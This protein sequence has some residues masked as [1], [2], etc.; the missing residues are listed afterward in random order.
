MSATAAAPR[1]RDNAEE[2]KALVSNAAG[3][4]KLDVALVEKDFWVTE[5]L[6]AATGPRT[7]VDKTGDEHRVELIFKGGTSLSRAHGLIERFSEDV[8]LLVAFPQG[9]DLSLKA[10][11]TALKGVCASTQSHLGFATS[12]CPTVTSTTGVKRNVRYLYPAEYPSPSVTEGVLLEMGSRGGTYPVEL[13]LIRSMVA[14]YAM[15]RFGDPE[16]QWEEF[17]PVEVSVLG[18]ERTLLEKLALLHDAASRLSPAD[19]EP[20]LGAGRHLYDVHCLLKSDSVRQA[21]EDLGPDGRLELCK[22]IDEHSRAAKFTF[23]PRP[24]DGYAAGPLFEPGHPCRADAERGYLA[25]LGL[26]YGSRP[27]FEECVQT[28]HTY[29][30]LL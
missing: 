25:S 26:V 6:R 17:A 30:A 20:L 7:V 18:A 4:L 23:T 14:E 3:D 16:S 27:T 24:A 8:D 29:A 13:H 11:D 22:D 9:A 2:F 15:E 10:R 12:A 1:L 28:V 19:G 5:V 21:L